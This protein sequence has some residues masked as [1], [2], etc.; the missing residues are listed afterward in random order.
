MKAF[1]LVRDL[2]ETSD[3]RGGVMSGYDRPHSY[4]IAWP[5]ARRGRNIDYVSQSL[6]SLDPPQCAT[7]RH[8]NPKD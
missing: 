6:L 5:G 1:S 8:L 2:V 4:I 3:L 7:G